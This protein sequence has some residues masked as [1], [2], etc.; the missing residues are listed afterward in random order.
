VQSPKLLFFQTSL[1]SFL[2]LLVV[3]PLRSSRIPGRKPKVNQDCLLQISSLISQ[4][5]V[6]FPP[7]STLYKIHTVKAASLTHVIC[8][9]QFALINNYYLNNDPHC[10]QSFTGYFVSQGFRVVN[11]KL[12]LQLVMCCKW[13]CL[14][15]RADPVDGGRTVS[16]KSWYPP[17]RLH[18]E[19]TRIISL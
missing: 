9:N 13:I 5:T 17:S 10:T 12:Y 7:H 4:V 1:T 14:H 3:S 8:A 11:K 2:G 16:P 18:C 6:I 19:T 15:S